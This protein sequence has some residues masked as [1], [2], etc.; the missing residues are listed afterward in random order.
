MI[1]ELL[2]VFSDIFP[3][4]F[5]VDDEVGASRMFLDIVSGIIVDSLVGEDKLFFLTR[6]FC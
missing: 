3:L 2:E 6:I 1:N 5:H 4:S